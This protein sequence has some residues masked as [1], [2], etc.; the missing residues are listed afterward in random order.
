MKRTVKDLPPLEMVNVLRL[1]PGLL[2]SVSGEEIL[3]VLQILPQKE[4]Q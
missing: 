1:S 3:V 2:D 4:S